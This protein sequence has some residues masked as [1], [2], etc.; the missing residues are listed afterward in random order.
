MCP[1]SCNVS[2]NLPNF[3]SQYLTPGPE[4]LSKRSSLAEVLWNF[5]R[6][7]D[8]EKRLTLKQN[9]HFYVALPTR[10]EAYGGEFQ[11]NPVEQFID[12]SQIYVLIDRPGRI[13]IDGTPRAFGNFWVPNK[14]IIFKGQYCNFFNFLPLTPLQR[15]AESSKAIVSLGNPPNGYPTYS[16]A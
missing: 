9:P 4:V 12:A 1:L 14:A 5:S 3:A 7:K 11:C 2:S 15:S 16:I 8:E 10:K 13:Y 6:F